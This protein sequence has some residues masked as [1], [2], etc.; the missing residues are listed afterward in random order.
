[1][2]R[3]KSNRD[4]NSFKK[5]Q[6]QI[7]VTICNFPYGNTRA[8][9]ILGKY[10][11]KCRSCAFKYFNGRDNNTFY[12]GWIKMS[13]QSVILHMVISKHAF[14]SILNVGVAS[15]HFFM[16]DGR[17]WRRQYVSPKEEVIILIQA[18]SY[19]HISSIKTAESTEV[20][21]ITRL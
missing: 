20:Q 4:N 7:A 2:Q 10:L 13:Q 14:I 16:T 17:R 8:C 5:C 19:L 15:T 3:S 11:L 21:I 9:K 18:R 1:M 12:N 6:G